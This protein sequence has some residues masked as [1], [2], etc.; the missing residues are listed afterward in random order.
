MSQNT[1]A[2]A[3]LPQFEKPKGRRFSDRIAG[4]LITISISQRRERLARLRREVRS[5]HKST[6]DVFGLDPAAIAK[7]VSLISAARL[8]CTFAPLLAIL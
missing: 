7:D 8:D 6:E 5:R 4:E 2:D 3:S 1:C